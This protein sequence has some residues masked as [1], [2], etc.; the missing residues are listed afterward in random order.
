MSPSKEY[1]EQAKHREPPLLLLL[2]HPASFG[3]SPSRRPG[4]AASLARVVSPPG[5]SAAAKCRHASRADVAVGPRAPGALPRRGRS[6]FLNSHS[7]PR[8]RSHFRRRRRR[9]SD[10]RGGGRSSHRQHRVRDDDSRLQIPPVRGVGTKDYTATRR[11]SCCVL[12]GLPT[13][14]RRC[15]SA[16]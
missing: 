9:S 13:N 10:P 14:T 12:R 11:S 1:V 3:P 15:D 7:R 8:S 5:C 4:H 2:P 16:R 6:H